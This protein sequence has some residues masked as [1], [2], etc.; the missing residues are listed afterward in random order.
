MNNSPVVK[1][2]KCWPR[3]SLSLYGYGDLWKSGRLVSLWWGRRQGKVVDLC[4]LND[5]TGSGGSD[6][7]L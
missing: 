4:I 5:V 2:M 1:R 6:E 7:L 3:L